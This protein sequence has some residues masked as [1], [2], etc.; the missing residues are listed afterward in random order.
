M[1][2]IDGNAR[3]VLRRLRDTFLDGGWERFEADPEAREAVEEVLMFLAS[4]DVVTSRDVL[5]CGKLLP[6]RGFR[7]LPPC[8]SKI[9]T[10]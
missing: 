2:S 8:K 6:S 4:A 1:S 5:L 10:R 9:S 3:E 7:P